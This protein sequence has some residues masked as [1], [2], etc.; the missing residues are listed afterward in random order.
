MHQT[1]TTT[2]LS[3]C[4]A[5]KRM[6]GRWRAI[7]S[8]L[9]ILALPNSAL[10]GFSMASCQHAPSPTAGALHQNAVMSAHQ[11]GAAPTPV[12]DS[13]ATLQHG[14]HQHQSDPDPC[15]PHAPCSAR[16]ALAC[17]LVYALPT[18]VQTLAQLAVGDHP[19][20]TTQREWSDAPSIKPFRPPI[21]LFA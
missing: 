21:F 20:R 8:T 19:A 6:V 7:I 1:C 12:I 17:T 5:V 9:L 2:K 10:A 15:K 14:K 16:C 18:D 11:H 13:L 3:R 4:V